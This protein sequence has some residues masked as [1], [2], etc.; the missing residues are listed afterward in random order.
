M[1]FRNRFNFVCPRLVQ[2]Y[3]PP[4]SPGS[5]PSEFCRATAERASIIL[6]T[7]PADRRI[8]RSIVAVIERADSHTVVRTATLAT[9]F[10]TRAA[11]AVPIVTMPAAGAALARAVVAVNLNDVAAQAFR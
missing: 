1:P 11:F 7:R 2:T 4:G 5:P 3:W 10:A 8:R 9:P 6:S